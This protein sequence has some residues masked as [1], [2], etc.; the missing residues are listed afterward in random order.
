[1]IHNAI[2]DPTQTHVTI[3]GVQRDIAVGMTEKFPEELELT[4]VGHAGCRFAD[5][6]GLTF[7]Q[8]NTE[9]D[10]KYAKMATEGHVIT[11][12]VQSGRWGLIIDQDIVRR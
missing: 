7:I 12:I 9:K 3:G 5:V 11:W 1:M 8:Q 6:E 2:H 4:G 10:T